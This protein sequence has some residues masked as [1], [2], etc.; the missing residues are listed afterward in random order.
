MNAPRWTFNLNKSAFIHSTLFAVCY[1]KFT[2]KLIPEEVVIMIAWM[3]GGFLFVDGLKFNVRD[4]WYVYKMAG[5]GNF[6]DL[7]VD[8][9]AEVAMNL[10]NF[11]M[12]KVAA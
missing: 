3:E 9:M 2:L 1:S 10:Y 4:F 12:L 6:T 7:D 5:Y 8:Y 11:K